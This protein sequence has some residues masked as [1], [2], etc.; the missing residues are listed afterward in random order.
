MNKFAQWRHSTLWFG[1]MIVLSGLVVGAALLPTGDQ[2]AGADLGII[3]VDHDAPGAGTGESWDDA[4]TSVQDALADA[5]SGD[6]IW[7]AKGVYYPDEGAGQT[8]GDRESTFRLRE[9]VAL[10]GGFA[11]DEIDRSERD[12]TTNVT[13]LSG[14]I[15]GDDVIDANGVVKD[16]ANIVGDNAYHVVTGAGVTETAVLNGFVI[17]AGSAY[18]KGGGISNSGSP[19]LA[20]LTF[21]GNQA[22]DGGGMCN[23]LDTSPVL[24]DVTFSGNRAEQ[25]GGMWNNGS[26]AKLT[27]VRFGGNKADHGGGMYN[28]CASPALTRVTLIDNRATSEGGGMYNKM[29]YPDLNDVEFSDNEATYGGGMYN[30]DWGY[31]TLTNVS[32]SRNQA[33]EGGGIHNYKSNPVLASV[34][35][36]ANQATSEGGGMYNDDSSPTLTDVTFW[37]NQAESGG[38]M[39][40]LSSSPTLTKTSFIGN[41]ATSSGGGMLNSDSSPRLMGVTF[42]GNLNPWYGGGMANYEGSSPTLIKVYFLMNLASISGSGMFNDNSSPTLTNVTFS[43][44]RGSLS[45]G[46]MTNLQSS[47][48]ALTNVALSGNHAE[49]G[50][51][52]YNRNSSPTLTN[53]TFSGNQADD[54]GGGMNN[55]GSNTTLVNC[56]LWG[57]EAPTGPQIHNEGTS[58]ADVTYSD[59]EDGY[60]GAGNIAADPLFIEPVPASEAPTTDGDYHLGEGSPAVDRASNEA[61][62]EDV[63]S[64][65]DGNPRIVD[66]TGDGNAVVDMGAYEYLEALLTII[67]QGQGSVTGTPGSIDCGGVCT[68]GFL[69]GTEVSLAAT[70]ETGWTFDGW[71]G[72]VESTDNP[73]ELTIGGDT[74]ITATFIKAETKVYLPLVI[75]SH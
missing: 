24:T 36:S 47:S 7:V 56:I 45:G 17:T 15:D 48:P 4:Y 44:N 28:W 49:L 59:I 33:D 70:A 29:A 60:C 55:Y 67:K 19:T 61:V 63:H 8:N 50:G 27:D 74:K 5:A 42:W 43:G 6:E 21:S 41:Q 54:H 20:N 16:A 35:F 3:Y 38:G 1:C 46:G 73:L 52:M 34:S 22:Q 31:P 58:G 37:D 18:G 65:L 53:V 23:F 9:G 68:A 25:G 2:R 66:G 14:D 40:N 30:V 10:Y 72:D 51:G 39:Y 32:F 12:R 64:D 71:S 69:A 62:P 26:D 75:R 11:G 13:V 57:N